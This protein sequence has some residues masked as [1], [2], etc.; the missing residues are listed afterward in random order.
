ML[1]KDYS[2]RDFRRHAAG[3]LKIS[4][5]GIVA[6]KLCHRKSLLKHKLAI[7]KS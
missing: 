2:S 7:Y 6:S 1:L 3:I 4:V 5:G